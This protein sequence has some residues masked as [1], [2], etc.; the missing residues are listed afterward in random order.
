ML[1]WNGELFEL[2]SFIHILSHYDFATVDGQ[3][4]LGSKDCKVRDSA[5]I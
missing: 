4:R 1:R 3:V 2:K 5:G